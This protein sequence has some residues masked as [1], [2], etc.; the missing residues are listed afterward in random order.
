MHQD[1][2]I[3]SVMWRGKSLLNDSTSLPCRTHCALWID[4]PGLLCE[5][6]NFMMP[7]EKMGL[8]Q[9]YVKL[10]RTLQKKTTK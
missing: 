3:S 2:N 8:A 1:R 5:V 4:L 6:E 10:S 9:D 7:V